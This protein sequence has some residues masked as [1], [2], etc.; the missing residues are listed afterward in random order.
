[1]KIEQILKHQNIAAKLSKKILQEMAEAVKHDYE[2]DCNDSKIWRENANKILD[3]SKM[4]VKQK[5]HPFPNSSNVKFPMLTR[6]ALQYFSNA[7]A[8][9]VRNNELARAII[10]GSDINNIKYNKAKRV[11]KW[12][13]YNLIQK[14]RDWKDDFE[15]TLQLTGNIG[16]T[17]RR[18][19]YDPITKQISS[20][21]CTHEE[22]VVPYYTKSIEKATR[23]SHK[24]LLDT[25]SLISYMRSDQF[26]EVERDELDNV[27]DDSDGN[28]HTIIGQ[29][30]WW[31]LDDDGYEEPYIIYYHEKLDKILGIEPRF[32]KESIEYN[33]KNKIRRIKARCDFADYHCMPSLDGSYYSIGF[34]TLLYPIC[35]AHNSILNQIIDAGRLSNSPTGFFGR[36]LNIPSQTLAMLPGLFKKVETYSERISDNI[37]QLQF[38]QPSPVLF[39]LLGFLDQAA[40][41][42]SSTTDLMMGSQKMSNAATG[43]TSI[44]QE[45]GM[46]LYNALNERIFG[47][48]GKELRNIHELTKETLSDVD[49]QR[50]L[51]D[52]NAHVLVDFNMDDLDIIP[53]AD[54]KLSTDM[55]KQQQ[56]QVLMPYVDHPKLNGEEIFRRMFETVDL[57]NA[58]QLMAPKSNG[59]TPPTPAEQ[60][61]MQEQQI[62]MQDQQIKMQELELKKMQLQIN[63]KRQQ[64]DD[65]HKT[66]KDTLAI[67][68]ME[69]KQ[70][71]Q[72]IDLA[73]H[74]SEQANKL[75]IER[76][77]QIGKLQ[78]KRI[79]R[80]D[81]SE[82]DSSE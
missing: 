23:I 39:Q 54:P 67:K 77:K 74:Q 25:N 7:S 10:V 80:S 5:N 14:N 18:Q 62:K 30:R 3:L 20:E 68:D 9:V 81:Y 56:V 28:M 58:E 75:R 53:V 11:S 22:V 82:K 43:A 46:A 44:L 47:A 36:G 71:D 12:H 57:D 26:I 1:M 52:P 73:K 13:N 24:M 49:Y 72:Q 41:E 33:S 42:L 34:G 37:M 35:K 60:I 76:L 31:D 66:I 16:L 40:K 63:A 70:V 17:F 59:Q 8:T 64:D 48:L 2:V 61:Q 50:V 29:H 32:T 79:D 21:G 78:E 19:Y 4:T 69:L 6:A 65:D 55:K 51:D 38:P 27:C 45:R 15:R